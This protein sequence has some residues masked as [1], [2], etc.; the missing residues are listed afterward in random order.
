MTC[1]FCDRVE[2]NKII[3]T[4]STWFEISLF[5]CSDYGRLSAGK[6]KPKYCPVCGKRLWRKKVQE[7]QKARVI[8]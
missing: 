8:S 5:A 2:R 3:A 6:F 1:S 7:W 4:G